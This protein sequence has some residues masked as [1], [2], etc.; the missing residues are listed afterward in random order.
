MK[1]SANGWNNGL[2]RHSKR[3][4]ALLLVSPFAEDAVRL[5][6]MLDQ[7]AWSLVSAGTLREALALLRET[8]VAVVIC[9]RD[10]PD[11]CW[12][13][14]LCALSPAEHAPRLIVVSRLADERLWAEVM[15]L[16]GFD[17]ILKPFYEKEVAWVMQSAWGQWQ[18]RVRSAEA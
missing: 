5:R 1:G 15:N 8:P 7:F 9:E 6:G 4:P 14:V 13:D 16:G 10:L 11:G 3:G 17:V 12:R 2:P 18:G